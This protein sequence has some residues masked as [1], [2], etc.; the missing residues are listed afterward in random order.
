MALLNDEDAAL[1]GEYTI[2]VNGIVSDVVSN[3]P[4]LNFRVTF[5]AYAENSLSVI[6]VI[7]KSAYTDSRGAYTFK[8]SGFSEPV[9]CEITA[10]SQ[11]NTEQYEPATNKIVVTWTGNSFDPEE[12]IFYVNDCNFQLNPATP[13]ESSPQS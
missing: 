8:V 12:K 6:P 11:E 13:S 2:V 9:T 3:D 5:N 4:L 10:E 1:G 7:T